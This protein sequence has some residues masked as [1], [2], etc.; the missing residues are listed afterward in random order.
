MNKQKQIGRRYGLLAAALLAT[1]SAWA[2]TTYTFTPT[3]VGTYN[4]TTPENWDP[5]GVPVS[6]TDASVAFFGDITTDLGQPTFTINSD[7]AA[8][9]LNA[10]TLKGKGAADTANTAVLIGTA[11]RTWTFDGTA[12]TVNLEGV[13]GTQ[14]LS[15][16]LYPNITLNQNIAFTGN[17][18][19]GFTFAGVI[20]ES[21]GAKALVKDGSGTLTLTGA[22]NSF[23]GGTSVNGGMLIL[24]PSGGSGLKADSNISVTNGTVSL[25]TDGAIRAV[26]GGT[27][28]VGAG[29][30]VSAD[31][32]S[33]QN[34]IYN[35]ALQGGT[36]GATCAGDPTYG[37][38]SIYIGG[39][40][41][42][43]GAG[44]NLSTISA[45][46]GF[47]DGASGLTFTVADD[48][49]LLVS[50]KIS[51]DK[52]WAVLTKA[53]SGTLTFTANNSYV[54][55]TIVNGGM[56][57]LNPASGHS[58]SENA[59]LLVSNGTVS[60]QTAGAIRAVTG[61][62]LTVGGGGLVSADGSSS[63]NWIHNLVMQGGI[64]GATCAGDG[65]YGNF[66]IY[67]G[68]SVTTSGAG[69]SLSTISA[70]LG[71]ID[72]TSG[73]TFTV[74]GD[75]P[76]LV[77]GKISYYNPAVTTYNPAL[78]LKVGSGTLTLTGANTYDGGTTISDGTLRLGD[79]TVNNGSVIGNI[80]N[81]A[82][83]VFANPNAQSYSGL[84]SGAGLVT[85][86]GAGTLSLTQAE[87]F[88]TNTVLTITSGLIELAFTGTN[89]V[90]SLTANGELQIRNHVYGKDNLPAAL[91]GDGFLRVTDGA[92][93]KG[94]LILVF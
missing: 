5:N 39:G 49:P 28:T 72:G 75:S 67:L 12:P 48:S 51:S 13:N 46:L 44:G 61:G 22:N 1:G 9:T 36:L 43:S 6:A 53:G 24:N 50:G 37:N 47:I 78:L 80:V 3:A 64:V 11:G 86:A 74:A 19:A 21:G 85:K 58:L 76:L 8:L 56:L 29:G 26:G 10:L 14:A 92:P 20:G 38:F 81:N 31:G 4:W 73:L 32:S 87:C 17:G 23:S 35:L 91:S 69:G 66:S 25:R 84:I 83:L 40:V 60:L 62:T 33:S 59:N 2:A 90:R 71:F 79:G 55:D 45:A 88:S 52:P 70:A 63:Q 27:L 42:T 94:T 7:P 82:A 34:W 65:N 93:P 18:T 41:T 57:I 68:G 16:T 30:L 77:S 54:G 15:F 89:T